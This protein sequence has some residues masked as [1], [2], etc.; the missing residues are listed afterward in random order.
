MKQIIFALLLG[1]SS[2][3][4]C[5]QTDAERIKHF[6]LNNNM[7]IEGYD[8][9]AYFTLKKGV[10]GKPT[11]QHKYR[12]VIYQFYSEQNKNLFISNPSRFEPQYGG[13]CAFAM[14]DYGKKVEVD[15][16]TF[17]IVND[18]LYLF[19]NAYLNNTLKDWNKDEN[20]LR[21]KADKN[22]SNIVK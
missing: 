8:P 20:N 13:W 7:A 9:V 21:S 5:Q 11:I 4:Y 12:G 3:L 17:K 18:K 2:V 22:W 16:E 14:G 15:P 6:N 1:T 10:K 19:Y